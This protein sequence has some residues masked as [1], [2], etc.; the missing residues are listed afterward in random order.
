MRI[1]SVSD[2]IN[3]ADNLVESELDQMVSKE[4]QLLQQKAKNFLKS[5]ELIR[6]KIST[7][8]LLS[9]KQHKLK[10]ALKNE[11][12]DTQL[13][14]QQLKEIVLSNITKV[15]FNE[16]IVKVFD[17]QRD[18]NEFLG[19]SV[20]VVYVYTDKKGIPSLYELKDDSGAVSMSRASRGAGITGR[21]NLSQKYL[22]NSDKAEL[23]DS[24]ERN[25]SVSGLQKTY[26]EVNRRGRYGQKVR[27]SRNILILW[28]PNQTWKKMWVSSYGDINEAYAAFFLKNEYTPSFTDSFI[29]ALIDDFM[30]DSTRGVNAVTNLSGM[31]EGDVS[32]NDIEYAIKSKGAS[33]LS[34]NQL[35]VMAEALSIMPVQQITEN[36]LKGI[37]EKMHESEVRRNLLFEG[38]IEETV[39]DE[40][41]K[42]IQQQIDI[43]I[44]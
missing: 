6:E 30:L 32:V 29:E 22:K 12:A 42:D 19:Q 24:Q 37:K 34:Y 2:I 17:F 5:T 1:N 9:Q 28:K 35:I 31:L 4:S 33:I 7:Y 26:Q 39:M 3:Y 23:L 38:D 21:F 36:F 14:E 40:L 18:L 15:E 11:N 10:Q 20:K 25:F 27:E 41:I 43:D 16:F 8:N 44:I 13:I